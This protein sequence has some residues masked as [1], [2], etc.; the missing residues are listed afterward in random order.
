MPYVDIKIHDKHAVQTNDTKIV[1]GNSDYVARFDFD[2]EWASYE[3]KAARFSWLNGR[4]L[5]SEDVIFDGNECAIPKLFGTIWVHIGVFAGDIH[6][7][8]SA[9][10]PCELSTLCGNGVPAD[11][12]PDVYN[13]IMAELNKISGGY[14]PSD[15]YL[16]A[17]IETDMLPA[18][19]DVDGN[20]LTNETGKILLRY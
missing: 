13:Q 19:Y 8:T 10:V 1:C 11:P 2:D 6:S 5:I 14:D 17:L 7:T 9:Q 20:I 3:T 18:V 16:H 12:T 4:K 15:E